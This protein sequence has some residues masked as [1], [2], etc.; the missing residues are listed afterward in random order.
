M[1]VSM[2]IVTYNAQTFY[3]WIRKEQ[4]EKNIWR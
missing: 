2:L 3:I 1:I 4:N